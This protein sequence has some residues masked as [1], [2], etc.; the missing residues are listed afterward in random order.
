MTVFHFQRRPGSDCWEWLGSTDRGYGKTTDSVHGENR[1]HRAVWTEFMGPIS[2]G[3]TLDHLCHNRTCVNP[4]HM[5]AVTF[6]E[7]SRRAAEF[8]ARGARLCG[9]GLHPM[10]P[11][12]TTADDKCRCCRRVYQREYQRTWNAKRAELKEASA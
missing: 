8:K 2:D 3:L 7:N 10:T 4:A 1:A 12:N 5:E 11:E 9:K 6:A